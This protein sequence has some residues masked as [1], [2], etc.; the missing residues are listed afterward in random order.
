MVRKHPGIADAPPRVCPDVDGGLRGCEHRARTC[1]WDRFLPARGRGHHEAALPRPRR[2]AHRGDREAG[3]AGRGRDPQA[4]PAAGARDHQ[5]HGGRADLLQPRFR[6]H[7]QHQRDGRRD[8]DLAQGTAPPGRRVH[9]RDPQADPAQVS[10]FD[11][12]LPERRHRHA[13]AELRPARSHRRPGAGLQ[14]RA[15][16]V[17]CRAAAQGDRGSPGRRGRAAAAGAELSRAAG[18]GGPAA[19]GAARLHPARRGQ[20]RAHHAVIELARQPVLFPG[21]QRGQLRRRGAN[22]DREDHQRGRPDVDR[23]HPD[24]RTGHRRRSF[25][26]RSTR[27]PARR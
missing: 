5:R 3:A 2:P 11:L 9:A 4:D 19:R 7:R 10:G 27:C 12:L 13:G 17:V 15:R 6:P 26:T 21:A 22:A 23:R 24:G 14:L 8:P 25:L 1:G 16:P 20:Q 18:R